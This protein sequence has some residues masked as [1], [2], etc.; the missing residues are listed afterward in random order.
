MSAT[1]IPAAVRLSCTFLVAGRAFAVDAAVVTEVFRGRVTTT[2]PRG[3]AAIRG[4]LNLRG[5]IVPAIDMRRRLGF[6][7]GTAVEPLHV[8]VLA[9]G[10]EAY[11]LLVDAIA[12]VTEIAAAAIEPPTSTPDGPAAECIEGVHAARGGLV[13]I[14]SLERIVAGL[15]EP[16]A[17]RKTR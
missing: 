7:P 5:R 16:M 12:D 4:L 3:P 14:L 10:G 9:A 17:E 6:E 13:Y 15:A 11:S 1:A 8:V 2:V